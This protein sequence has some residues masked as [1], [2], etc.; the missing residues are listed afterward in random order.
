MNQ[1]LKAI[2]AIHFW[3]L[4]IYT[5]I[6]AF[7][8]FR[9]TFGAAVQFGCLACDVLFY[10]FF[11]IVFQTQIGKFSNVEFEGGC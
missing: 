8:T 7:V 5:S 3:R 6:K 10:S 2:M 9:V 1:S 4:L 11:L